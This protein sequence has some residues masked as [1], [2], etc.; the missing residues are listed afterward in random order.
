MQ[1]VYDLIQAQYEN[2]LS[3]H[4]IDDGLKCLLSQPMN[5]IIVNFPVKLKDGTIKLFKGYRV[6]HNNL[7]GPFKGGIRFYKDVYLDECKALA[8]WMTMKCAL[9]SLPFGGGKGGI[10]FNPRDYQ[11]YV[12]LLVKDIWFILCGTNMLLFQKTNILNGEIGVV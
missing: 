9:V 6:Q 3:K 7:L 1:N 11:T 10:K 5:E 12:M 4:T 8:F 2:I